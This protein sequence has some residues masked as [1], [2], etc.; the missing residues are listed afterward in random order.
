[1]IS[2]IPEMYLVF[3]KEPKK[4]LG[5]GSCG[6]WAD[7]DD[8][9]LSEIWTYSSLLNSESVRYQAGNYNRLKDC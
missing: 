2:L 7:L 9:V 6:M 1:M 5:G 4:F 3:Y 8:R